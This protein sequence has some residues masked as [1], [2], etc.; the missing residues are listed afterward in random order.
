MGAFSNLTT[1]ALKKLLRRNRGKLQVLEDI[2]KGRSA[3]RNF[4]KQDPI[5]RAAQGGSYSNGK[6]AS[7]ARW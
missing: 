3:E 7:E 1:A 6:R 2:K 5:Y 4:L